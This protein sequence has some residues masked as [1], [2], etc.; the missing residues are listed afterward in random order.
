MIEAILKLQKLN[1]EIDHLRSDAQ[2]H[3]DRLMDAQKSYDTK[4][5]KFDESKTRIQALKAEL[6]D[7]QNT[8]S[9]EEQRL[10]KSRK[11]INELDKAY[12]FQAMKKEIES[13][14]RSNEELSAKIKEKSAEVAKAEADFASIEPEYKKSEDLLT[15]IRS[16]VEVKI[17]EF[18]GVLNQKLDEV[19][20]LEAACDKVLLSKYKLIRQRK[21]QDAIVAVVSGACQ[22]CFMNIP[23]QMANMMRQRREQIDTCPNCQRLIFWHEEK[24]A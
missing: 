2:V 6:G 18:D 3:P 17:G 12:E 22:G 9:L 19:K 20:Q 23:P 21:Y 24:S 5:R 10:T 7:F 8:L 15:S 16:E 1:S 11:K 4:K 13:T 14:E